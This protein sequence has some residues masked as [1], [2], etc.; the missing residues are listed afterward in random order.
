MAAFRGIILELG[1][2]APNDA[3]LLFRFQEGLKDEVRREVYMQRP[4]LL[5]DAITLAE[6][7]D[8][9]IYMSSRRSRQPPHD[10]MDWSPGVAAQASSSGG[11][12]GGGRGGRGAGRRPPRPVRCWQ[13][14]QEGHVK[15]DCPQSKN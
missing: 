4:T 15:R 9:A 11:G 13:C 12:R 2:L 10:P 6:R 1:S 14:G 5:E 7:A 3:D 8:S